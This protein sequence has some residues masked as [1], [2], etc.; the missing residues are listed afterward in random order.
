RRR[1]ELLG[2]AQI[3]RISA[4][5]TL[6]RQAVQ[7]GHTPV[8]LADHSDRSGFATWLLREIMA[9]GLS[10]TLVC[11][12]AAPKVLEALAAQGAKPGDAFDMEVGGLADE[13]AGEPVRITGTV[14]SIVPSTTARAM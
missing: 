7:E 3:H 9:Q 6:A 8:V 14:H 4:G 1:A 13:S 11:T 12:V 5:V 2:A 10:R